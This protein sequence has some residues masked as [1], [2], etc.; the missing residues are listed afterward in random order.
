MKKFYHDVHL[1]LD[2][3]KNVNDIILQIEKY[4]SYTIA[5]TNL[6][7]LYD[8]AINNTPNSKYIRIALGF[9]PELVGL[10]PEQIQEFYKRIE[11]SRYIGEIGLDFTKANDKF[12]ELQIKVFKETIHMC[13]KFGGKILSI[14]SRKAAKETIE[15]IGTDF[16][17]KIILHWFSGNFTELTKAIQNGYYFSINEEMIRYPKGK[18]IINRIPID[19]ILIESDGPFIK[20]VKNEYTIVTIDKVINEL[21]NIKECSYEEINNQLKANFKMLL[22]K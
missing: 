20:S 9:H 5:V 4:H 7:I 21:C 18:S 11:G 10:Y 19:K 17:G 14:H 16:N 12:K 8:K 2:L 22:G 6:P 1:H 13:N 15:I 3:Y